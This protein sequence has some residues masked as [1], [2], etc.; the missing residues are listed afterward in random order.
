M[1][2]VITVLTFIV[3]NR[4][5]YGFFK[6]DNSPKVGENDEIR[7]DT[8]NNINL[9]EINELDQLMVTARQKLMLAASEKGPDAM[10]AVMADAKSDL[11]LIR[12]MLK[13]RV[14][15]VEALDVP[16]DS[17]SNVVSITS[18]KEEW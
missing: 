13:W 1:Y 14:H 8:D 17:P 7:M 2:F 12:D 11:Y 15:S 4:A 16:A 6:L 18:K 3:I 5:Y 9:D 10:A